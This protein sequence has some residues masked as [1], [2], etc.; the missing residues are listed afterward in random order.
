MSFA[1]TFLVTIVGIAA[2]VA[3]Y[4]L[5]A[6]Q[7]IVEEFEEPSPLDS[8]EGP[9]IS[10]ARSGTFESFAHETSGVAQLIETPEGS[11]IRLENFSVE[12]GPDLFVYL[13]SDSRATD[14][15]SLGALKGTVGSANYDVPIGVDVSRYNHVIIWCRAFSVNFGYA[16]I[17]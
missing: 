5:I 9:Y 6:P 8:P 4:W 17:E 7:F 13:A 1:T 3:G 11:V 15:V 16:I 2:L 10:I 12:N 14:F